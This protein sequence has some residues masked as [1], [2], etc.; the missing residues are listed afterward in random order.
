MV[1][2]LFLKK[3]GC[4]HFALPFMFSE[5]QEEEELR[6]GLSKR[7]GGLSAL[8]LLSSD[9]LVPFFTP[10]ALKRRLWFFLSHHMKINMM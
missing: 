7:A 9:S 6:G 2:D 3:L 8:L 4:N 1:N 5:Q 10:V